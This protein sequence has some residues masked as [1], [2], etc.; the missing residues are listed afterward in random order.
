M[1]TEIDEVKEETKWYEIAYPASAYTFPQDALL[2]D[3]RFD[4]HYI[5]LDLIDG[6]ILAIPLWWVPTL[7]NADPNER[8]KYEISRDR[9]MVIWNP[10]HCTINDEIRV[11][12]YLMTRLPLT[13]GRHRS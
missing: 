10:D 7:L 6:R 8:K 12:D 2:H 3:I 5:Y 11:D 4:E 9:K 13:N 1:I